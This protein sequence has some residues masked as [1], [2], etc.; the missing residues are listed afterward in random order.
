M[1][2]VL[3]DDDF[4]DLSTVKEGTVVADWYKDG[5]RFLVMAHHGFCAYL[6]VPIDHPL[7]G[8][9]YDDIPLDC[10][11]GLTF[12]EAGDDKYRPKFFYWYGWDYAHYGDYTDFRLPAE[13]SHLERSS[14]DKKWTLG[15]IKAEAEEVA[16]DF[17]RLM[18][19]AESIA[20]KESKSR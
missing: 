5:L 2:T 10:H 9:G 8:F 17:R 14:T 6:G 13:L 7:A 11:G 1:I 16:Y 12:A 18:R 4:Y 19:L 3:K 20:A 15:E